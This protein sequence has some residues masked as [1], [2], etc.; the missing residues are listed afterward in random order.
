MTE[1]AFG[2]GGRGRAVAA[3][4]T[5]LVLG[6][7][8]AGAAADPAVGTADLPASKRFD[9][10]A[11]SYDLFRHKR[12]K[13]G[14]V[15]Q[16]FGFDMANKRL[17]TVQLKNGS[18]ADENGDL[19]V[20]RLDFAGNIKG[21][22][23]LK[24]FGHGVA[25]GVEPSGSAS[26]LWVEVD[27]TG[28]SARGTR[29][30]RFRF[31]DG[32]TLA[33]TSSALTKYRPI[34]GISNVSATIDPVNNRLAM[35]YHKGG[36]RIAVYRLSD[37]KARRY[38]SRLADIAQ[39]SQGGETFQGYALYG[40][41][42]YT[43]YGNPYGGDNP[44]PGNARLSTVDLNTGK[45]VAGPTLTKAGGTLTYREPEGL[46][47]Y[48]TASGQVRLFLGIASGRSGDR[49]ANLFYNNALVG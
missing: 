36:W 12:L 27:P 28:E 38:G 41:Y 10:T 3:F 4:A 21:H 9:L 7:S 45:R 31:V 1:K 37:V 13:D 25:I 15:M 46:A 18:S 39:P 22:M 34:S 40:R 44:A 19:V 35:R 11:P 47:I 14:T 20:N 26:Y 17:F 48:R 8:P 29:L 23:Y 32:A 6:G 5:V 42:L 30:A 2:R 49:R 33:N 24:G 16:S 43:Y